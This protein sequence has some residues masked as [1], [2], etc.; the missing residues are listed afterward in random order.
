MHETH[1]S[2]DGLEMP[3]YMSISSWVDGVGMHLSPRNFRTLACTHLCTLES[4]QLCTL[5]IA[6]TCTFYMHFW[7]EGCMGSPPHLAILCLNMACGLW[8]WLDFEPK[9][10][11]T[12][13][14]FMGTLDKHIF[15]PS[16]CF[17]TMIKQ[18]LPKQLFL[19]GILHFIGYILI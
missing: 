6:K 10:I 18:L 15:M 19:F 14:A 12:F 1:F 17:H 9:H 13:H 4:M 2:M 11:H 16:N 7:V 8:F 5:H 3:F